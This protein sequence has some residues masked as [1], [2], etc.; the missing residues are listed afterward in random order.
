MARPLFDSPYIFGMHDPGGEQHML[1]AGKPGWIVFT[2]AIGSEPN[3][4]SG[5]N[6]TPW[7]NQG[8]GIICRINNGYEPA[9]TIPHSGRYEQF[10]QRCANYVAASPGCKIWIIGNEMNHPVERPGVQIDWSRTAVEADES[11]RARMVPWRFNALDGET[12]S[13]RMAV[14]NPGE[15]ITPQLYARCY[16]LCRDAIK[17]VPGHAND[18]V[19]VGA[20][21]PWNTLTKYEGNPTGDWVVYHADIL[22]LLGAQNCDGVTIHTYTHSPDPAQIYTDSTMD[23]PFQNRQYNFRAYRDF[24]NAIPASM[25]HLPAYITETDQDVAWL[26]QNNGWV[27]RAYGEIDWWNKQP[28]NQQI[29]SLVLYR[30]PP[31]DRWV[32]EGKQGVIDGWRE[33][34]RN[35]YRWSETPVAPSRPPSPWGRPST[36]S[37]RPT[38]AA[39]RA[40]RASHR[41]T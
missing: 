34:M 36:W 18:Q 9:G 21:A 5:K 4:H 2:E 12:R 38:C 11:A 37:A 15:V 29:R 26:N 28:G 19:L 10:A 25:R 30:W 32:I 33:A 8:L 31:A 1:Q 20:T 14:V 40:M 24:M 27:Q 16:R 39:A 7:S 3:D 6:F 22:K 13:T 41:A 23:P 17:R 35:D